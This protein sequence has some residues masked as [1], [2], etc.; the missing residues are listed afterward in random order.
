ML[1]FHLQCI[2]ATV[3]VL[4]TCTSSPV[5]SIA[6]LRGSG[7]APQTEA[8]QKA[9]PLL[10]HSEETVKH[11]DEDKKDSVKNVKVTDVKVEGNTVKVH[12]DVEVKKTD[13][14]KTVEAAVKKVVET[15]SELKSTISQTATKDVKHEDVKSTS[16][17]DIKHEDK[18]DT[19][20]KTTSNI[21]VIEHK[22]AEE[23]Q[24]HAENI[25]KDKS[26]V[27]TTLKE[28]TVK[29]L[30]E[31]K[32]DSVKNVKVTDVKV[33]GNTVKVHTD[34][35]VKKTDDKKTVEAAVKKVVE[36]SSELKGRILETG[37]VDVKHDGLKFASV[38]NVAVNTSKIRASYLPTA[39]ECSRCP[40]AS[41]GRLL[42]SIILSGVPYRKAM[43][44]EFLSGAAASLRREL[45]KELRSEEEPQSLNVVTVD[46]DDKNTVVNLE[47]KS[48]AGF[49]DVI[50]AK[51]HEQSFIKKFWLHFRFENRFVRNATAENKW[52]KFQKICYG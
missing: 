46:G 9:V 5:V 22:T 37:T 13:D 1:K 18:K 23:A 2:L 29:H 10:I 24:K 30:D 36:T 48:K 52:K 27:S 41:G 42:S 33:E 21:V 25:V 34:V 12:T 49:L 19:N 26:S 35:E 38:R 3:L 6:I 50:K 40:S 7:D 45:S 51:W 47:L 28:E 17:T 4:L 44:N 15:S 16:V 32:K 39:E 31:D 14:K 43:S 11:L 20:E 8:N